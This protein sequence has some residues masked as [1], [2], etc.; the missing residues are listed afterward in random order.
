MDYPDGYLVARSGLRKEVTRIIRKD[1]PDVLLTCDP[2]TLYVG[3]NRINHPDHRAAGQVALDAVYPAAGDPLY[4]P[5]LLEQ[6]G[7]E[8]HTSREVWI[9]GTLEPNCSP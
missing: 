8:P 9:S 6:E 4:F 2:Q 5:E 1:R 3:D 7:L